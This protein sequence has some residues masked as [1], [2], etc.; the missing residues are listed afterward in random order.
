M[1]NSKI[2]I[3]KHGSTYIP[4]VKEQWH[5]V[6][7]PECYSDNTEDLDMTGVEYKR[8]HTF[9]TYYPYE[10]IR[11]RECGC[12]YRGQTG[13]RR[14]VLYKGTKRL[15]VAILLSGLSMLANYIFGFN[16]V[17]GL[18]FFAVLIMDT[19]IL[20]ALIAYEGLDWP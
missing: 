5:P 15:I 1:K 3:I 20:A 7:C 16:L 17:T 18:A 11:C 8:R 2:T 12:E 14:V 9:Y 6:V 10:I 13:K 4:P 19:F